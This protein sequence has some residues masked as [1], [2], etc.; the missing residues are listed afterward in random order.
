KS[1][2]E[3]KNDKMNLKKIFEFSKEYDLISLEYATGFKI[4][5]DKG[6]PYFIKTFKKFKDINIAIV[7]TFLKILSIYPDTLIIRKSGRDTALYISEKASYI[8]ENGG[9]ST[10]KGLKLTLELDNELHA[11]KGKLNPGTTADLISGVIFCA[12]LIGLRF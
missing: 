9:I 12:L 6:L 2:E 1:I 10:D 8:L 11:K 7:N 4:I 3:L 5:L